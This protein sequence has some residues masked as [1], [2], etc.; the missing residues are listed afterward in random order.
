VEEDRRKAEVIR[1]S[2]KCGTAP[3]SARSSLEAVP[4][5][6]YP[7]V[8]SVAQALAVERR[9]AIWVRRPTEAVPIM[10][11]GVAGGHLSGTRKVVWAGS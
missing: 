7:E 10:I 3:S 9:D 6:K 1:P 5:G 4:I 8:V 2:R 11:A